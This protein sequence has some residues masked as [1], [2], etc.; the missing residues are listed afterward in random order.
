MPKI[1]KK[2]LGARIKSL[3][4]AKGY[5]LK[6][7]SKLIQRENKEES[8]I[9]ESI[10]SRWERGVSVPSPNRL[11]AIA[12]IEG[13]SVDELLYG[14]QNEYITRLLREAILKNDRIELSA[15][16]LSELFNTLLPRLS[17]HEFNYT[18][19][20]LYSENKDIIQE[21]VLT[22]ELY[23]KWGLIEYSK[24]AVR[25]A[26]EEV[27]KAYNQAIRV[28]G[29]LENEELLFYQVKDILYS[30]LEKVDQLDKEK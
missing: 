10:I 20:T 2:A 27:Q 5:T 15:D 28:R 8:E 6:D 9:T 25:K 14:P 11:K 21:F 19:D 30:T 3:R 12:N 16:E 23:E 4:L 1:D 18:A 13:I 24:G 17:P 7:F 26:I 29:H 22:N